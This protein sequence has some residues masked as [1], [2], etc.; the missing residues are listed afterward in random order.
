[1]FSTF[2]ID[3]PQEPDSSCGC[4]TVTE[5]VFGQLD[6]NAVWTISFNCTLD[7]LL[8]TYVLG[9]CYVKACYGMEYYRTM[10]YME[11]TVMETPSLFSSQIHEMRHYANGY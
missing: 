2:C 3:R 10:K 8:L 5:D 4:L 6:H 1:M 9:Y 11:W 7:V